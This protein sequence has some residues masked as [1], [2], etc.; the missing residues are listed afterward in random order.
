M[1]CDTCA[2]FIG[3][4]CASLDDSA[5]MLRGASVR[6]QFEVVECRWHRPASERPPEEDDLEGRFQAM[7]Q[8][9]A[10]S[11][12]WTVQ[13]DETPESRIQARADDAASAWKGGPRL[14]PGGA[15]DEWEPLDADLQG[16]RL[17][18]LDECDE[19]ADARGLRCRLTWRTT[20]WHSQGA[21]VWGSSKPIPQPQREK[22]GIEETWEIVLSL[23]VWMVLDGEDR[24]RLLHHELMHAARNERGHPVAE[25]P[26]TV[27]R[28]G[29]GSREQALLALTGVA[30]KRALAQIREWNVLPSGQL[31]LLESAGLPRIKVLM[32]AEEE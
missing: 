29:L 19:L 24:D 16:R 30:H 17:R 22:F 21:A 1:L 2:D 20:A 4:I 13:A 31:L 32:P 9:L 8:L 23:P 14:L 11:E 6:D 18:L 25:F 27:G 7:R 12:G 10:K 5:R 15:L 26:E 28:Y 3:G